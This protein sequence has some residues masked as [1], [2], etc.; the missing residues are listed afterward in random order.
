VESNDHTEKIMTES[1]QTVLQKVADRLSEKGLPVPP[2]FKKKLSEEESLLLHVF[3]DHLYMQVLPNL[4]QARKE[5]EEF[6]KKN[7]N[8]DQSTRV[9]EWMV[10]LE[11]S[12][13]E[14]YDIFAG[15]LD[16][17]P[18]LAEMKDFKKKLQEELAYAAALSLEAL[19]QAQSG[20]TPTE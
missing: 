10:G 8:S 15:D 17:V 4:K 3:L 13:K 16:V 7:P 20:N 12:L 11:D 6:G 1:N 9:F 14:G 2:A 19:G 18:D 5:L